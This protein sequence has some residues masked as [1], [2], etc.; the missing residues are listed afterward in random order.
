MPKVYGFFLWTG[1][2]PSSS[3]TYQCRIKT[4]QCDI[5]PQLPGGARTVIV[6]VIYFI[7]PFRRSTIAYNDLIE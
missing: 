1:S 5:L 3:L 7:S 6:P 2:T 4:G